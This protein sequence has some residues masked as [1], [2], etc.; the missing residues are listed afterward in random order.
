MWG[1]VDQRGQ[2]AGAAPSRPCAGAACAGAEDGGRRVMRL[3]T[4]DLA[5]QQAVELVTN[6]LEGRLSRRQRRRFEAHLAGCPHCRAYLAQ[7]EETIKLP[8]QVEPDNLEP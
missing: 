3:L 7:I 6:Y 8:G 5:C 2:P 4:S 1:V